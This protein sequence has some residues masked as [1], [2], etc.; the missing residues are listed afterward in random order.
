MSAAEG[1]RPSTLVYD[2]DCAFCARSVQFVLRHDRRQRT[3]RFAARDGV[4]GRAVRV[5]HPELAAVDSMVWVDGAG[6]TEVTRVR[7]DA[8]LA[9]AEYLGGPWR[10]LAWLGRLVPRPLRDS[11]Y[12]VIARVRRRLAGRAPACVVFSPEERAR[13]LD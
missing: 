8:V 3:L 9:I 7:S 11:A 10:L 1:A 2:G 13:A 5:R 12:G 4:A 6:A